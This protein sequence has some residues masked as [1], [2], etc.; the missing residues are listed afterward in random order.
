MYVTATSPYLFMLI[1]LI[2]GAILKGSMQGILYYLVPDFSKLA[3]LTVWV[4]A[5]SQIFFSY[6]ISLGVLTAL[7][8]YNKW[9][10]N[11]YRDC[12]IFACTNSGTSFFAGFVIFSTLGHMA[13]LQGVSVEEVAAGGPGL[14]F[15]AYPKVVALMPVAPLW[16]VFFFLMIILL[17][18]D[19]QFVGVEGLVTSFVDTFSILKVKRNK[20]I[21]VV[22]ICFVQ[23]LV[24]L[25]MVTNGGMYV[26]QLFDYYSGSKIILFIAFFEC[27]AIA[28]IYG[29]ERFYQNM[30]M[31]YGF[32]ISPY[33][34]IAWVF[35]APVFSITVFVM[36]IIDYSE[37]TYISPVTGVYNYPKWAIGIGWAI[38]AASGIFIPII[39]VYKIIRYVFIDR[40]GWRSIIRPEGLKPHQLRPEDKQNHQT[41]KNEMKPSNSIGWATTII[42]FFLNCYY[43][44][45]LCWAFYYMFASLTN[46]LPWDS[47][48]NYW[49]TENC[50]QIFNLYNGTD[51]NT[52]VK[53]DP[54]TE[55]W[56]R[57]VL[58]ISR[59]VDEPVRIKWDL[60]LTLLCAWIVVFLCI[61]KGI[62]TSGKVMYVTA[63]TPYI[64]MLILLIRGAV[65]KGSLQGILYYLVPDFTKLAHIG[66]GMY[67]FQLFDYYSGSKIIL[68]VA[69]FECV[70]IAWIYGA[71]RFYQNMEVMFGFRI[72]PYMKIGWVFTAPVFCMSYY[73][74]LKPEDLKPHQLLPDENGI[75]DLNEEFQS[76]EDPGVVVVK[77]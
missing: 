42:V 36:S 4:D 64:F 22:V 8:S 65:L 34:K 40:K 45:I 11:S 21:F 71:E 9:N 5:G 77:L 13:Y 38:A 57:K 3:E 7:G 20:N 18:L 54:T 70:A 19:S 33:M 47:C 2:R 6:A 41:E 29:V 53:V 55:F 69:F 12:I 35:T 62:K 28:W 27:A 10:H 25:S 76:D 43:N 16:S 56:E 52:A 74:L 72:S 48:D 75:S 61:F 17:G 60:G 67:V 14:A 1:L 26:F 51:N 39:A 49:N 50:T 24:G 30:E 15:I 44:V 32:R 68:F 46:H 23:F 58:N 63:T 73:D 31:M 37:L 59:G 66:G